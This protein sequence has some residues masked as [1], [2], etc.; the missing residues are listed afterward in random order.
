MKVLSIGSDKSLFVDSKALGR[1]REYSS[2]VESYH[3]VIFSKQNLDLTEKCEANLYLHPTNSRNKLF[4]V[5]DALLLSWKILSKESNLNNWVVTV[6]DPFESGLVGLVIK[7]FFKIPLQVQV[8]TD[9]LSAEFNGFLNSI[10]LFISGIVM[11]KSDGIRVVS[12]VI[13]D[14]I[15]KKYPKFEEKIET[16]PIFVDINSILNFTPKKNIKEEFP[17]FKFIIL[18][19]SRLTSEKRIDLAISAFQKI[20]SIYPKTGLIICGSGPEKNKLADLAYRLKVGGSVVFKDWQDDLVSYFKT[21][22]LYLLTSEYEGYGMTLI[23]ASAAGAPIVSTS[24]GIAKT[25]IFKN[26]YNISICKEL[27]SS[28]VADEVMA[29][30]SNEVLRKKYSEN[31]KIAVSNVAISRAEYIDRYVGLLGRLIK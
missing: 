2:R 9:F 5:L 10:R 14:S 26:G 13:K 30:I 7:F 29:I 8:H 23:E 18:M 24:V 28:C 1:V 22:D 31:A 19:A 17:D 6:Q 16:L 3:V 11:K 21:A 20:I 27:T 12:S 15:I 25:D 4:Y